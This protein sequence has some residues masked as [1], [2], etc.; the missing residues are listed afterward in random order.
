MGGG[1]TLP[2]V[3]CTAAAA[4]AAS[5]LLYNECEQ[6]MASSQLGVLTFELLGQS[7]VIIQN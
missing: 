6:N 1:L 3:P 5:C 7:H 4:A 2:N